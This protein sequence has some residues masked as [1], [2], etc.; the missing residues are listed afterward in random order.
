MRKPLLLIALLLFA[1]AS[2]ASAETT[3]Y[4]AGV[5]LDETLKISTLLADPDHYAGQ[6]VRVEGTVTDVCS[7][8]GCWMELEENPQARVRCKVDDGVIVFPISAKGKTGR[9][10]GTVETI[11]MTRGDYV[12]WQKH[13][14]EERGQTF[15]PATVGNGP[16]QIVQIRCTGA[17]VAEP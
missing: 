13:L 1:A 2:M 11:P 8:Q 15:D 3:V 10:E 7:M 12:T 9:A 5:K 4:G 17:E 6:K 16:F 14:A